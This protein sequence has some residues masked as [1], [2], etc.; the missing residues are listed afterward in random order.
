MAIL[1]P[2]KNRPTQNCTT[3]VEVTL[4]IAPMMSDP[5]AIPRFL[6][7]LST[8]GPEMKLATTDPTFPREYVLLAH[9]LFYWLVPSTLLHSLLSLFYWLMSIFLLA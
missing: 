2:R 4:M 8:V 1:N 3:V 7:I 6:P 9:H 5:R